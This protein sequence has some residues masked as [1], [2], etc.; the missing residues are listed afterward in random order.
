MHGYIPVSRRRMRLPS[1]ASQPC[2]RA[3][4]GPVLGHMRNVVSQQRERSLDRINSLDSVPA[5]LQ[6]AFH[7]QG[8]ASS[9][10]YW[11]RRASTLDPC[12]TTI[13]SDSPDARIDMCRTLRTTCQAWP[14]LASTT[15]GMCV[16]TDAPANNKDAIGAAA[17]SS[18]G[19]RGSSG[20]LQKKKSWGRSWG[21][22][23]KSAEHLRIVEA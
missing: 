15:R 13:F 18:P 16:R 12:I 3:S 21:R 9:H 23:L 8:N 22:V 4:S 20:S 2:P 5:L 14:R 1:E 11:P 6:C 7:P 10:A 17:F 19:S